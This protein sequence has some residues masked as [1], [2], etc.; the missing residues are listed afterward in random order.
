[1]RALLQAGLLDELALGVVP[2]VVGSGMRLF[3][4]SS[5]QVPVELVQSR[6]LS[7][8]V[9]ALTTG[10]QDEFLISRRSQLRP[11]PW[12]EHTMSTT[13]AAS[14]LE[15][16]DHPMADPRRWQAL[17]VLGL[18]RSPAASSREQAK[19]SHLGRTRRTGRHDRR[20]HL[21]DPHRR[22]LVARH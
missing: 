11:E 3:G 4:E 5:Q 17:A 18:I 16:T 2:I 12:K 1:M 9:L 14:E 13:I 20:G 6:A 10:Q 8:G 7:T 15:S 21:R 19:R 22:G